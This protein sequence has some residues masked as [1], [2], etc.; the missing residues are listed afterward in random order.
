M[1]ERLN[2][3]ELSHRLGVRAP[4]LM[5]DRLT[6]DVEALRADGLKLV[7]M[8]ESH[9]LGHF[10]GQPVMPGVL[11]VGLMCQEAQAL[12]QA[13]G[14]VSAEQVAVV[15]GVRRVKF[16]V[17]VRP[18]MCL[19]SECVQSAV[20]EN[21]AVEYTVKNLADGQLASSGMVTVA[22]CPKTIYEQTEDDGA[23]MLP[24]A[25]AGGSYSEP[26]GLM[27]HLPH[28]YPFMFVD[29]AY[30]LDDVSE[31]WG[32]KN[33]TC[34]GQYASAMTPHEFAGYLQLECG[35]QLGCAALLS[36]PE[37]VGK[38]GFFMSIDTATFHRPVRPGDQLVMQ[39][40]SEYRGRYGL[41]TGRLYVGQRLVTETAIK[42]AI[43][44]Q[45]EAGGER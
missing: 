31:V 20:L 30:G 41:A 5:L 15:T 24:A 4:L 29:R 14:Q 26:Q 27:E 25:L 11:Q 12:F 40:C 28:R 2:S 44:S 45:E 34:G 39:V 42:F 16:R 1:K 17:P 32:V 36:R 33:V 7:S 18:G 35:A 43:V 19:T 13:C 38:L 6:V 9:F 22:A 3:D 10:P 37:N 8:D 23:S 21:G